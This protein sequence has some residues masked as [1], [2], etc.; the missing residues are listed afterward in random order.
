MNIEDIVGELINSVTQEI[1]LRGC[2]ALLLSGGI[3]TSFVALAAYISNIE[4]KA[5]TVVYDEEAL[6]LKYSRIVSNKFKLRHHIIYGYERNIEEDLNSVLKILRVIDPIEVLCA[7][8]TYIGIVKAVELGSN[9]VITG[10][11]GDELF[12]GYD[13][14]L[15]RNSQELDEW[16]KYVT[17]YASFS[18]IK[19]GRFLGIKVLPALFTK[20]VRELALKIPAGFKIRKVK[21]K[22]Y[23]KF[24]LRKAL[25]LHNLKEIA[26]RKKEPIHV[27]SGFYKL[28]RQWSNKVSIDEAL[29]LAIKVNV[30]FPSR[31]HVY[32]YKK[33][34]KL[35]LL[36]T[37]FK[38]T[39]GSK[40]PICNSRMESRFC[41]FCGTY[42]TNNNTLSFH[43]KDELWNYINELKL[44]VR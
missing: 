29:K 4:L 19:I 37:K 33:L 17:K 30:N 26:W 8:P 22:K 11:G 10:D 21:D 14:L 23:G 35:G 40:C 24:I 6:D 41:K 28:L 44:K 3:D 36:P 18:S 39:K 16:I 32:L 27:G 15:D 13:F 25:E 34:N 7:L 31:P 1:K 12:L 9:C 43:Y 38:G 20:R 5:V 2:D 42:I